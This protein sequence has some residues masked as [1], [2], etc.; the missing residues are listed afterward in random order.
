MLSLRPRSAGFSSAVPR[1]YVHVHT[2]PCMERAGP[3]LPVSVAA[4]AKQAKRIVAVSFRKFFM[5]STIIFIF[6]T[7]IMC[8]YNCNVSDTGG[9]SS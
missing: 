9:D 2:Q 6:C 7:I 8:I 1:A 4:Q 3:A 5:R